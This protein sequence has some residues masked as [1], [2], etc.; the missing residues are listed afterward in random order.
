MKRRARTTTMQASARMQIEMASLHSV[1][2][3]VLIVTIQEKETISKLTITTIDPNQENIAS[4]AFI[5]PTLAEMTM[6]SKATIPKVEICM[7]GFVALAMV[8]QWRDKVETWTTVHA[9]DF[10]EML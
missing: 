4:K 6:M 8:V 3:V 1:L 9:V 7:E 10:L 2:V 5:L